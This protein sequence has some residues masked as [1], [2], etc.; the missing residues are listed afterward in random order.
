MTKPKIL[1]F[2]IETS[3]IIAQVWDL[4]DQNIA[5]NQIQIDWHL[6]AWAAKWLGN[7]EVIYADQSKAKDITND[8]N[9]LVRLW[10]LLN[11]ADIVV[12]Q[13]GNRFDIKKIN[14]RFAIHNMKPPAP[15]RKVDTLQLAKKHFG[16]TSNKLAYM[17]DKLCL[18]YKKL[19]HKNFP[20]HELWQECLKGNKKAWKEMKKYNTHD[21]L[22]L[23]EL[24]LKL[25]PWGTGIDFNVYS[26][27]IRPTCNCGSKN[28]IRSGYRT[29]LAGRYIRYKCEDCGA[30]MASKLNELSPSKR[31]HFLKKE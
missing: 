25:A 13:N 7:K 5:L 4:F 27:S 26:D 10:N 29:T 11:E 15:Y 17:T 6:L 30:W 12:T 3:P 23:E 1:L 31:K 16:F 18:K 14:A 22:A 24:Y 19:E 20:G 21:V 9:I 8:K 28:M 2:D